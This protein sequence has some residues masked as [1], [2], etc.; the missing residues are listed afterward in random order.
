ML[1]SALLLALG[2]AAAAQ[3]CVHFNVPLTLTSR[4][5]VFNV[6]TPQTEIDVTNFLLDFTRAGHNYTN[7]VITGVS[8]S[9]RPKHARQ[10]SPT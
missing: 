4:N 3:N 2:T 8:R 1:T 7:S 9:R 5:G 6:T 10:P